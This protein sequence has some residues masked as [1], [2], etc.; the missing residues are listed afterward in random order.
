MAGAQGPGRRLLGSYQIGQ[1]IGAGPVGDVF[2]AQQ[3]GQSNRELVVKIVRQQLAH[4]ASV[5]QR[6]DVVTRNVARLDHT[7]ILPLE[8]AGEIDGQLVTIMPLVVQGSLMARIARGR[9]APKDI[10]PLFKQIC[11]ALNYAHSQGVIH[12]NLKPTN[13]LLF[14]GR[15]VLLG[16]FG[17]LWQVAETDLSHAGLSAD[18]VAYMA[19][20]Q[21]EG[22]G[23]VR[24]DIY[25]L[26]V[27]LYQAL[28]GML[29]FSGRAPFD[30]LS[31]HLR[32]PP[33]S[34][35][36]S[37]PPLPAG[38][39][40][41]DEVIQMAL[42]KDPNQRFQ[43]VVALARAIA[44]A[45][46]RASAMPAN[47][48]SLLRPNS[49]PLLPP[50]RQ[51]P[52]NG[53]APAYPATAGQPPQWGPT[54]GAGPGG[55]LAGPS[56]QQPPSAPMP[57]LMPHRVPSRPM[58]PAAGPMPS[59][60]PQPPPQQW[61]GPPPMPSSPQWN[62]PPAQWGPPS[63]P[64]SPWAGQPQPGGPGARGAPMPPGQ[65]SP[66]ANGNMPAWQNP[67]APPAA[68]AG[69]APNR[70]LADFLT[71]RHAAPPDSQVLPAMPHEDDV[72]RFPTAES[73]VTSESGFWD[74]YDESRE[75]TNYGDES[76]R[77]PGYADESRYM[78][79]Y[80]GESQ[81]FTAN[82]W[83]DA[84]DLSRSML[85]PSYRDPAGDRSVGYPDR[86][87]GSYDDEYDEY[88]RQMNRAQSARHSPQGRLSY[89]D[90]YSASQSVVIAG[91]RSRASSAGRERRPEQPQQ[92]SRLPLVLGILILAVLLINGFLVVW[93]APNLCPNGL[94][95]GLHDRL[96]RL[97]P[98]SSDT[99]TSP[100]AQSAPM[101]PALRRFVII[102]Q[103]RLAGR[104][105][106][107]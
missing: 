70:D 25:S 83:D 31:R 44:E 9:L 45:G 40:S 93:L 85:A 69:P 2:R 92:R 60:Q 99:G 84:Y 89:H 79:G 102:T 42:N 87:A 81:R 34:L 103:A 54:T 18:A 58:M 7:H 52:M 17:Q 20:E 91:A 94:C 86:R 100:I 32:Q 61:G 65:P 63:A 50:P 19:P 71:A 78:T 75:F 48:A 5:R 4:S 39:V 30:V 41:F 53:A 95:N 59:G 107:G 38:A 62:A 105:S 16:D 101:P 98:H 96:N 43:S 51:Q 37:Q 35:A 26:G 11:D 77:M 55:P 10:A 1:F 27:M 23:D 46:H 73:G 8:H 15:H 68:P 97:L 104:A 76:R 74:G 90:D 67:N 12:N 14:E 28:T 13:V 36:A 3:A 66:A 33:P 47:A 72:E 80:D 56:P 57:P 6:F 106:Q 88:S 29:P 24:S 82:G 21:A 49:K 22:R 64:Q